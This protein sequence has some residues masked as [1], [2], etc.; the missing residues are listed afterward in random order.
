MLFDPF[1][2]LRFLSTPLLISWHSLSSPL[3]IR[4]R[5]P[6]GIDG[7]FRKKNQPPRGTKLTEC[8]GAFP[9]LPRALK[10]IYSYFLD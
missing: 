4:A 3:Y 7:A 5:P 6:D 2:P 10:S 9:V 8:P 1:N